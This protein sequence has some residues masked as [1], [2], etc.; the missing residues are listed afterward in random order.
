MQRIKRKRAGDNFTILS[1]DFLRDEKLSLKA[2]GLLAYI[3]SLPDDWKIYF[4]EVEKHHS[5]GV[6]G[7]R[8]AWKNLEEQGYAR[9]VKVKEKG[10]IKEWA[11]EVAD[12]KFPDSG[13]VDVENVDVEI[14]HVENS[15]LLNT[16]KQSTD[17]PKTKPT[18]DNTTNK[19]DELDLEK[20]FEILWKLYP[21][22]AGNKQKAKA[23]YKKAVKSGVED[24]AIK[25]GILNL[26]AEKRES[27]FIPHGQTWFC[28]ERWND[29]PLVTE[30]KERERQP[31][32][33]LDLPF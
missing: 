5:D 19:S 18:K 33:D 15:S 31:Y 17:K 13:F 23:A 10:R 28:N 2:K 14:L 12:F 27:R 4:E 25:Q 7:V 29:E 8:S 21:R 3:L 6:R 16:N 22:K 32:S 26:I 24:A 11:K 30:K 1:N 20:R 9:T